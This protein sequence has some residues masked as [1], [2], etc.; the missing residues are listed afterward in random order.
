MIRR[1]ADCVQK[2][3]ASLVFPPTSKISFAQCWATLIPFRHFNSELEMYVSASW[4]IISTL[5]V[6]CIAQ[7]TGFTKSKTTIDRRKRHISPIT[8]LKHEVDIFHL[9]R[10][11]TFYVFYNTHSYCIPTANIDPGS[12]EFSIDVTVNRTKKMNRTGA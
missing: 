3:Y 10:P 2:L 6:P 5:I 11:L 9:Q 4:Q 12:A 8:Q 1:A 7:L